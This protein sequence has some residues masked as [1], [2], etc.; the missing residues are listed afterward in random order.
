M[1]FRN[2]QIR[3]KRLSKL[4]A[5]IYGVVTEHSYSWS[6]FEWFDWSTAQHA[7]AIFPLL[8]EYCR[9]FPTVVNISRWLH[10][11][12]THTPYVVVA[13]Y[14]I[15]QP[16]LST[17]RKL[18]NRNEYTCSEI[19]VVYTYT[20]EVT[21]AA[22]CQQKTADII[23]CSRLLKHSTLWSIKCARFIFAITLADVNKF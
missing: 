3:K 12:N 11:G 16:P 17:I 15:F 1:V 14:Y 18:W 22:E 8:S 21:H 6:A 9:E 19:T 13:A 5:C 7:A 23:R 4:L 2:R 10:V 20:H